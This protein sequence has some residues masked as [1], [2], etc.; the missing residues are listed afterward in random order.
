MSGKATCTAAEIKKALADRHSRDYFLTEVKSGSTYMGTAN[1]I[2]DAAAL[3]LSW[4]NP[5]ITGYEVKVSRSDFTRDNK[6]FTYLPL[7]HALYVA[8]PAGLVGREELPTDIGL[9]WYDPEKKRLTVKK[10]PPPRTIE[11][12]RDM[13]MYII[14]SRLDRDRIPFYGDKAEYWRAWLDGKASNAQLGERVKSKLL[15][16]IRRLERELSEANRYGREKEREEY[17]RLMDI[18]REHGMSPWDRRQPDKW[19]KDRLAREYPVILDDIEQRLDFAVKEIQEAKEA[20]RND[21]R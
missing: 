12:S 16:E 8:T 13:L 19:L 17:D 21:A 9:V 1:R 14:Y 6:F 4:T 15:D 7:V 3:R 5:Y 20:A 11:I 18:M 10:K 2:L